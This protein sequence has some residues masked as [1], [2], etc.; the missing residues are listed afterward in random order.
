MAWYVFCSTSVYPSL[1]PLLLWVLEITNKL[2]H[3]ITYWCFLPHGNYS[4]VSHFHSYLL[5]CSTVRCHRICEIAKRNKTFWNWLKVALTAEQSSKLHE[6][7][8]RIYNKYKRQ[9]ITYYP[10]FLCMRKGTNSFLKTCLNQFVL[11]RG[12]RRKNHLI[13][14]NLR[15]CYEQV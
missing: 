10:I 1:Q 3:S 11:G 7:G 5:K 12:S 14:F 8:F 2:G 4:T 6:K 13:G 15:K 9:F